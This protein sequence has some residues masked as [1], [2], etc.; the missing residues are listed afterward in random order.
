VPNARDR[1]LVSRT[2]DWSAFTH[3]DVLSYLRVV[4][5]DR[6]EAS[7]DRLAAA[8]TPTKSTS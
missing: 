5:R 3:M 2:C 4:N 8:L 1:T 6:L 7:L